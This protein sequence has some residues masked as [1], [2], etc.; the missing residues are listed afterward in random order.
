MDHLEQHK[1][2]EVS[3]TWISTGKIM[4]DESVGI[5]RKCN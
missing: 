5:S 4:F 3:Q 1:L 2:I